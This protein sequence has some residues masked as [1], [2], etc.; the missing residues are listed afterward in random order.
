MSKSNNI[1]TISNIG[2]LGTSELKIGIAPIKELIV[3]KN[4]LCFALSSASG[5]ISGFNN[6]FSNSLKESNSNDK[7]S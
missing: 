5:V 2:L 4:Y 1:F 7:E 6:A 3:S